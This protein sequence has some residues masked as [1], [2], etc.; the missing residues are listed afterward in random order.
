LIRKGFST[1]CQTA[2][3]A[4]ILPPMTDKQPTRIVRFDIR[5]IPKKP[6][7]LRAVD[8]LPAPD[9]ISGRL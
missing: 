7:E 4:D 5:A 1:D 8:R 3:P 2:Q 6:P 9:D